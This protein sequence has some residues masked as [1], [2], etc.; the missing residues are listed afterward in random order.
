MRTTFVAV[1]T[2]LLCAPHAAAQISNATLIGTVKDATG[3]VVAGA[4]VEA[5][6]AATGA[7]RNTTTDNAGEY[8]IPSLPA[9]RYSV[10]ITM[11]GFKTFTANEVELQVAQ[12]VPLDARLEVGAIGQ[13]LTVTASAPMIDTAS[14][15][16]GA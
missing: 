2:L 16:V 15:S 14:S 3:A 10:S 8:S 1:L 12:R 9:G 13:E 4:K 6:N 7:A 11:A 5:K